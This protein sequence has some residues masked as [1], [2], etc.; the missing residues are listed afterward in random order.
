MNLN[1]RQPVDRRH[2]LK[3]GAVTLALPA[4]DTMLPRGLR[5]AEPERP[6][7]CC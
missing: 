5:A 4:L 6:C 1:L 7:A 2:F 3:A